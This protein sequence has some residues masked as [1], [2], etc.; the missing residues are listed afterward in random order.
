MRARVREYNDHGP[1][2]FL[3]PFFGRSVRRSADYSFYLAYLLCFF[4][5]AL[6]RL[7]RRFEV[8]LESRRYRGWGGC[9][10]SSSIC[11]L[12]GRGVRDEAAVG[13]RVC[14]MNDTLAH[15]Y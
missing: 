13:R 6:F 15:P 1:C 5:C 3:S 12:V 4:N 9:A 14:A 7:S 11:I 2:A 10:F 8:W